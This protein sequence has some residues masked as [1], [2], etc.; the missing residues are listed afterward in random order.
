MNL[1]SVGLGEIVVSKDPQDI[2]VAY[3][4]GSCLG[5]GMHDPQTGITGLL[6]A[7]LPSSTQN[8]AKIEQPGKYVD[9]GI[10]SMLALLQENGA[11]RSRLIV[12]VAG[13]ANMLTAPGFA[14]V[15]N[16]GLRNIETALA[17]FGALQLTIAS[18]EVGGHVGRTVR[19]YVTDGRMTIRT[20]GN[21]E[22]EV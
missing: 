2:L 16:I 10:K 1:L 13:G 14:Q 18:R 11:Q 12:R 22:R 21:Q 20:A 5:I 15:M 7:I 8:G 19:F 17:V 4:L 9:S 3:G 6:H